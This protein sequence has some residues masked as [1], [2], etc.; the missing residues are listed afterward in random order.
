MKFHTRRPIALAAI[1]LTASA[2]LTACGSDDDGGDTGSGGDGGGSLSMTMLPKTLGN[3]Y[4][5]TSTAGAAAA[6]EELGA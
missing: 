3:P 5:D 2:A 6:A 4:F 1:I